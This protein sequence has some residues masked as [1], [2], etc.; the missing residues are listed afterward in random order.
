M[1]LH[2]INNFAHADAAHSGSVAKDGF[3]AVVGH[4]PLWV[5]ITLV[6]AVI[7]AIWLLSFK[8]SFFAR[9][10]VVILALIPIGIFY[11][12]HNPQMSALVLSVGF[13]A[14]F[15]VVFTSLGLGKS[16]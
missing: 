7:A 3:W 15:L 13:I 6:C 14:V 12:P 11:L 10:L 1:L 8:L 2:A 16:K 9:C 5:S 4:Q